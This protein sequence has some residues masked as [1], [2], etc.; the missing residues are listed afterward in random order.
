MVRVRVVVGARVEVRVR[1]K[2]RVRLTSTVDNGQVP[3]TEYSDVQ[4]TIVKTSE[5]CKNIFVAGLVL[6]F[7]S[8][9]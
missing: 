5:F 3:F 8:C 6:L 9:N 4:S 7:C 1:V 2:I